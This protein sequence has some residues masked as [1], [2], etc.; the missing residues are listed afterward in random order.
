MFFINNHY[1]FHLNI[2]MLELKIFLNIILYDL[3]IELQIEWNLSSNH[4]DFLFYHIYNLVRLM[5]RYYLNVKIFF[6]VI[7]SRYIH[8]CFHLRS[9]NYEKII[10]VIVMK[11]SYRQYMILWLLWNCF[12]S[13]LDKKYIVVIKFTSYFFY[14]FIIFFCLFSSTEPS[15]W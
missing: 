3:I 1:C 5:K 12:L 8:L 13:K 15:T 4:I 11:L 6:L 7:F 9:K 14:C 2:K 10:L